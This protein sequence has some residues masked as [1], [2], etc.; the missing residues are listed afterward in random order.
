MFG[1]TNTFC[2][3]FFRPQV[4]FR[5]CF[6]GPP[7]DGQS[8]FQEL[9]KRTTPM[10]NTVTL[11]PHDQFQ[12]EGDELV[13]PGKFYTTTLGNFVPGKVMYES[14]FHHKIVTLDFATN[15]SLTHICC[16]N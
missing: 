5:F 9:C 7:D 4:V 3:F 10:E 14:C 6:N 8:I 15:S 1:R 13:G 11:K 2:F 16:F 12:Q